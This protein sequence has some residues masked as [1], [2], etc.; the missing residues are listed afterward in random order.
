[1]N[2][3]GKYTPPSEGRM[4]RLKALGAFDN[5]GGAVAVFVD[6]LFHHLT[7]DFENDPERVDLEGTIEVFPIDEIDVP[8]LRVVGSRRRTR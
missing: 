8:R 2:E 5:A 3:S 7:A 6:G 4:R 1:M